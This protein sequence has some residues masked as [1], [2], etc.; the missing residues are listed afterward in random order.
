MTTST[1]VTASDLPDNYRPL[2]LWSVPRAMS[3]AFEKM[4]RTRNDHAVF[5]EPFHHAWYSGPEK[6]THRNMGYRPELT[7][8]SCLQPIITS[9][10]ERRTFMR[11]QPWQLI[12]PYFTSSFLC[13][14]EPSIL[15]RSPVYSVPSLV[16]LKFDTTEEETGFEGLVRCWK[17]LVAAGENVPIIDSVDIQRDPSLYVGLWCDAVGLS[18]N[19]NALRWKSEEI[20]EWKGWS[21]YTRTVVGS[22]G[23]LPVQPPPK[24]K[25]EHT[26]RLIDSVMKHYRELESN[27][28]VA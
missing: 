14:F 6:G 23:F 5:A 25:N 28:L 20:D 22:T 3:H 8:Q 19:E 27:K 4:V 2:A 7:Y 11:A 9:A 1:T 12:E 21:Y 13:S 15:I 18:R 24:V 16:K 26:A 10:K 17:I